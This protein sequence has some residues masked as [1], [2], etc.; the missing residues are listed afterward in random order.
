MMQTGLPRPLYMDASRLLSRPLTA[1][2]SNVIELDHY[3]QHW[4]P[5]RK[6]SS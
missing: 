5:R 6:T 1:R 2:T 4:N 3:G